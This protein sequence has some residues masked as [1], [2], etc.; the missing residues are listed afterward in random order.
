MV[1]LVPNNKFTGYIRKHKVT[2]KKLNIPSFFCYLL[3][4][5]CKLKHMLWQ[6]LDRIKVGPSWGYSS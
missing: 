6:I 4:L 1:D 2:F 3:K 5:K